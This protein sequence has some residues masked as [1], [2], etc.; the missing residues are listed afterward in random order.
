VRARA[1]G[2]EAERGAGVP[3]FG[4]GPST[5]TPA[6]GVLRRGVACRIID[7]AV[8][9]PAAPWHDGRERGKSMNR[10]Q[11]PTSG[12]QWRGARP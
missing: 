7:R 8:A 9:G 1:M 4:A 5:F 2:L 12:R 10:R 3:V 6:C 11:I